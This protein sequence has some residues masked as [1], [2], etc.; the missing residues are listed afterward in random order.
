MR[1]LGRVPVGVSGTA[2]RAARRSS[3]VCRWSNGRG[4]TTSL[5]QSARR[6]RVRVSPRPLTSAPFAANDCPWLLRCFPAA[7]P[8]AET[9]DAFDSRALSP[10]FRLSLPL[11]PVSVWYACAPFCFQ[12]RSLR[13]VPSCKRARAI[14]HALLPSR[15]AIAFR[16]LQ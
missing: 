5:T 1:G 15:F 4:L 12:P 6:E 14:E 8:A 2:A 7:L 11:S 13:L 10:P 3:D 16:A 9:S